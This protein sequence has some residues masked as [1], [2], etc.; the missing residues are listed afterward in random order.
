MFGLGPMEFILI[1]VLGLF[2]FGPKRLPEMGK[3]VGH[4]LQEFKKAISSLNGESS[5]LPPT[6]QDNNKPNSLV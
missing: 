6:H 5:E 2:V 3:A 4:T 1:G